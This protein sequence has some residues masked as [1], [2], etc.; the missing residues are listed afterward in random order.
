MNND[1]RRTPRRAGFARRRFQIIRRAVHGRR[2]VTENISVGLYNRLCS[3]V[4][5]LEAFKSSR[6]RNRFITIFFYF[7]FANTRNNKSK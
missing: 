5:Q 2:A 3:L 4:F 7:F 6:L 1:R